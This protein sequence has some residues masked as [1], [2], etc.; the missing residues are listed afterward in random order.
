MRHLTQHFTS[1][2]DFGTDAATNDANPLKRLSSLKASIAQLAVKQDHRRR[3]I[4]SASTGAPRPPS[5]THENPP[6]NRCRPHA[7]DPHAADRPLPTDRCRPH[8]AAART[9]TSR[10]TS[11]RRRPLEVPHTALGISAGRLAAPQLGAHL[12]DLVEEAPPPMPIGN[13]LSAIAAIYASRIEADA[14]ADIQCRNRVP[15]RKF[16]RDYHLR[17][18][19]IRSVAERAANELRASVAFYSSPQDASQM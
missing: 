11:F 7:A 5:R 4:L 12:N 19:G 6:A 14:L 16:F 13:L 18:H 17:K 2:A 8:A 15:F 1:S 3:S 9:P 10:P